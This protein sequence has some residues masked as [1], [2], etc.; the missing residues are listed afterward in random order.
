MR[1]WM[2]GLI[3]GVVLSSVSVSWAIRLPAPPTITEW[4]PSAIAQINSYLRQV[5]ELTNGRL[6]HEVTTTNPNGSRVGT[7]G[8]LVFYNNSGSYK[9]CVNISSTTSASP[10]GTTWRCSANAFTAP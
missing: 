2:V 1:G 9:L 5:W 7:Q 6:T 8:D 10:T 4:N 3:V